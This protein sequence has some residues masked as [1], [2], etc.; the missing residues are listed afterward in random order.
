MERARM[1]FARSR[2]VGMGKL[3]IQRDKPH[4]VSDEPPASN[5]A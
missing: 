5:A 4:I 1:A 3:L 2:R